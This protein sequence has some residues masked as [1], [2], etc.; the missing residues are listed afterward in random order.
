MRVLVDRFCEYRRRRADA[1]RLAR[2]EVVPPFAA[3][4]AVVRA[5]AIA[6]G[7]RAEV[8]LLVHVLAHVRDRKVTGLAIEGEAPGVAEAVGPD[9]AAPRRLVVERVVGRDRVLAIRRSTW[10]DAEDLAGQRP[11]VL[12]GQIGVAPSSA[13]TGPHVQVTVGAELQLAAVVIRA[14][15]RELQDEPST[16]RVRDVRVRVGAL[17]LVDRD[18]S[19]SG[20]SP[21]SRC[22]RDPTSRSPARRPS[23]AS[24][25]RHSTTG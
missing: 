17:V 15:V 13:V 12:P 3:A 18:R 22:R 9:L 21:C 4:P 20:S 23:R 5:A 24:P 14:R 16:G 7:T 11:Q 6:R 2:I 1:K 8:D 10:I 19:Q 25:V